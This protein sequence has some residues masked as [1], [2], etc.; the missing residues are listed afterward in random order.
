MILADGA[1]QW[2]PKGT[3]HVE[4]VRASNAACRAASDCP[5]SEEELQRDEYLAIQYAEQLA[6]EGAFGRLWRVWQTGS[7]KGR[8]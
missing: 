7:L 2:T 1:P 3:Q 5:F 8:R 4:R 6:R